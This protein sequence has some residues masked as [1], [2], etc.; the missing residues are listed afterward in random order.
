MNSIDYTIRYFHFT[1][2][3]IVVKGLLTGLLYG[4]L[5]YL[6]TIFIF[7]V[8]DAPVL[9]SVNAF[10]IAILLFNRTKKWPVILLFCA[11]G[12]MASGLPTKDYDVK[13]YLFLTAINIFE[14][15]LLAAVL[16]K[17]T[18]T[19]PTR[20][21]LK[22]LVITSI[23]AAALVITVTAVLSVF[24]FS[25]GYPDID[26]FKS[27]I[28][29]F[30]CA[31]LGQ[32]LFLTAIL[33]YIVLPRPSL[34][35]LSPR[36]RVELSLMWGGLFLVI[37]I[38]LVNLN[39]QTSVHY[40]FPYITFPLLVW[41]AVRFSI[42]NTV[43]C[44]VITSLFAKYLASLGFIPFG[45][46][47]V[48]SYQQVTEMNVGLIALNFTV[49]VL[50]IIIDD[51]KQIKWDMTKREGWFQIAINH[52]SGGLYLLDQERRF[53]VLS[54]GLQRKF[55]LPDSIC[56][57]GGH[58]EQVFEFRAKRGDYGP[59]D[60]HE[61]VQKRMQELEQLKTTRGQN[62]APN[63]RV[64]EYFQNHTKDDEIIIFYNEITERIKAEKDSQRALSEAQH[65]NKAK[66]DF[67]ANMSHEL[68][69]PLNA[70]IGFSEIMTNREFIE[71]APDKV[72]EYSNDIFESGRHLLQIINDILDLSKIE[73]G[74]ADLELE[75]IHLGES[76][77]E[78]V[79]FLELRAAEAEI[80]IFNE[81]EDMDA[82][83]LADRRMFK[84]I[85]VNLLSNAVKFTPCGGS[86][87]ISHSV[88]EKGETT[89]TV[90]DTGIGMA[91]SDI[92]AMMEPFRQA[93]S[94]LSRGYE[95][96]GLGLPLV[97]SLIKLHGGKVAIKS[98]IGSG[99]SVFITFPAEQAHNS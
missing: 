14:I 18:G 65:A 1:A 45:T 92:E 13:L 84:Q 4:F 15:F 85:M 27:S 17:I 37:V 64:Y 55:E 21:K 57:V 9:W 38:T 43:S 70:I 98:E 3:S 50:A 12:L 56:H 81:I 7:P 83:I 36:E 19:S 74:M 99:T 68:R 67:L 11:I 35:T 20:R 95:G 22:T 62:A 54:K 5:V 80:T 89:I 32:V 66:T 2:A 28:R 52:M 16:R 40:I 23:W 77:R 47:G 51:Q 41:S 46:V 58:I 48:S 53:K 33:Y 72:K 39:N 29:I 31:Y 49:L 94:S 25:A 90:K 8:R 79:R 10:P 93:D 34:M 88:N 97:K 42:R 26:F 44:L 69:T 63:G 76:I 91:S 82:T 78:S 30:A 87:T 71:A 75:S 24:L 73:A 96:T 86:L 59:G 60:P 6:S 61:L